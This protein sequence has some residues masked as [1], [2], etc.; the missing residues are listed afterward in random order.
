[1]RERFLRIKN[2]EYVKIV[3]PS[4]YLKNILINNTIDKNIIHVIP[5]GI[6]V[7]YYNSTSLPRNKAIS[8]LGGENVL[9]GFIEVLL[10]YKI[11]ARKN[12]NVKLYIA[13]TH[14]K[15][16]RKIG[17]NIIYLGYLNE[18]GTKMLYQKSDVILVPSLLPEA[19]SLVTAE[20]MAS[21]RP[22]VAY[23]SG[24]INEL[25]TD[26]YN[27]YLIDIHDIDNFAEKVLY[28]IDNPDI[29]EKMGIN[30]RETIVKNFSL[31]IFYGKWKDLL[32][33]I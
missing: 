5:N 13:G 9:K 30:A 31:E 32:S 15:I 10:I 27:G 22:V 25:I 29:A 4:H 3:T 2:N 24:A 28:L 12:R 33:K 26:G 11:I 17:S 19:F 20:A 1:M 21:A 18:E 6:D 8:Y 23:K 7:N 16:E 14:H